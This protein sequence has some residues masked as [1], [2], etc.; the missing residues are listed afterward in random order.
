MSTQSV[1]F[2]APGPKARAR[3]AVLTGVGVAFVALVLWVVLRKLSATGQL[4][5]AKWKPFVT[6]WALWKDYLLLGLWGTIKAAVLAV[7]FAGIFGVVFGMGRLSHVAAVRWISGIVV[8]FFRAVPVYLMM[9]FLFFGFFARSSTIPNSLAPMVSVV[10]A[11][12]LYNGSVIAEL[13]R[14]GVHSLPKG[15]SEA[16]LSIG[17]TASQT[18]RM[19]QLPQALTAMLP[20][21]IS[22]FVVVLKDSALGFA[23]TYQELLTWAKTA[24]SA[25]A[26]PFAMYLVAAALFI[27]MNYLLTLVAGWVERRLKRTGPSS[28]GPITTV[29]P[30]IIQGR[31]EPGEPAAAGLRYAEH[32]GHEIG[33]EFHELGE[34]WRHRGDH[35]SSHPGDSG[36]H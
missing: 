11:L 32:A 9:V 19:I 27:A 14:A 34:R 36:R 13:V 33:E 23:I 18:L 7:V 22:Q 26:N 16:G 29:A 20:A 10:I 28:A 2:D 30:N 5:G 15:Q 1:L 21:L 35:D 25:Y 8:E 17:L 3:H 24:G 4:E 6:D 12:T 31:A